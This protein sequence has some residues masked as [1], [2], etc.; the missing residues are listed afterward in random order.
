MKCTDD[1]MT[2]VKFNTLHISIVSTFALF[3]YLIV[4]SYLPFQY[5]EN[6]AQIKSVGIL[7]NR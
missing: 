2:P 7:E 5:F 6:V 4:I 3:N 1:T